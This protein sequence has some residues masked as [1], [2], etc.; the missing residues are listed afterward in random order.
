[1]DKCL[2]PNCEEEPMVNSV[3]CKKH[4]EIIYGGATWQ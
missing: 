2:Y 1:M 3:Y 4:Y